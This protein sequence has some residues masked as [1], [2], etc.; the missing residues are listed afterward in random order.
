MWGRESERSGRVIQSERGKVGEVGDTAD[1]QREGERQQSD[2]ERERDSSQTKRGRGRET[3][4]RQRERGRETADRQREKEREWQGL[5][6][7]VA[8]QL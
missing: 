3:A 1:R 6:Q 8:S 4:D 5:K 2:K 7:V